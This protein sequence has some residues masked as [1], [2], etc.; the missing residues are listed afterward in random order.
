MAN[1]TPGSSSH[2]DTGSLK[3]ALSDGEGSTGSYKRQREREREPRDWRDVHLN[4]GGGGGGS[5][6]RRGGEGRRDSHR[7]RD[8]DRDRDRER[9]RERDRDRN[10][11]SGKDRDRDSDRRRDRSP[12]KRTPPGEKEEGEISPRPRSGSVA[13]PPPATPTPAPTPMEVDPERELDLLPS[14]PP[15]EQTLAERRARRAAILARH[16]ASAPNSN[17]GSTVD[18]GASPSPIRT[19]LTRSP[20]DTPTPSSLRARRHLDRSRSKRRRILLSPS[21]THLERHLLPHQEQDDA[22]AQVNAADY[23]PSL[24]RRE[25]EVRRVKGQVALAPKRRRRRKRKKKDE[26]DDMFAF[27]GA[28]PKTKK[29]KRAGTATKAKLTKA[30]QQHVQLHSDTAADAEGYYTVIL[31]EVLVAPPTTA[32]EKGERYQVYATVGKGMFAIVV[33]ARVLPEGEDAGNEVKEGREVAIK[34]VRAQEVMHRAGLKESAILQKLQTAD[35]EDKKHIV[36]LERT[37]EHRGHLCLVFESLSMNLRDVVKRFGKDVGLNIRAVRAYAHQ[38]FLALGHLR[39]LGVMHADIKPDNILVND[40][41][42]MLKLCDLGSASDAAENE[43][44]PYLVS[45]FYRAPEIILGVPYDPALDIWSVGCTLYELYTGKILFPGRSNNQMLLHMM[46]LKGRFNGKMIK[47]AK[48]GEVYFDEMGGFESVE[49]EKGSGN[50]VIRKVHISKPAR[51]L[52]ARLLPSGSARLGEEETNVLLHFVDLLDRCL[53]LDPARR[54]TPREALAHPF[55]R[56][57]TK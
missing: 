10:R 7:D 48:F 31:G 46:E 44:T 54:I 25:D 47:R 40:A 16:A 15:V 32:G 39:K 34:I 4:R 49:K 3:R 57:A 9:D 35:P 21:Q 11:G 33:R 52:R 12:R 19:K 42:T 51:D 43:I 56:G 28:K 36:R 20:Q 26:V 38:L 27:A 13:T 8:R 24:D 17:P 14:P 23:D 45:R 37:F 1:A 22:Q 5:G 53:A 55:I 6:R 2:T 29:K 30:A 50:D 18:A 41:K